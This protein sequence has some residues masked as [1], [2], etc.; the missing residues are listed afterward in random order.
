M[1]SPTPGGE[2]KAIQIQG[3]GAD[4]RVR[5]AGLAHVVLGVLGAPGLG[6]RGESAF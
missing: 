5:V 3:A 2:S 4:A 1:G 6:T